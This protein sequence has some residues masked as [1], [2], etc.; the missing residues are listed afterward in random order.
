MTSLSRILSIVRLLPLFFSSLALAQTATANTSQQLVFAG[1]R[2]V[3]ALGQVNA[4]AT[5]AAGD[6][7]LAFDQKDGVRV[8]KVANDGDALL[9]QVRLGAK[10]DSGVAM[11]LDPAGNVYI[12]GTSTSGALVATSGAAMGSATAG[13]T[14]SFVAKFDANLNE[15]FLTF[16]GGTRIAASAVAASGDAVFVTGITYGADLPV[17]VNGIEQGPAYGSVQNGFVEEFS[18]DGTTLVYATYITGALGDTTPTGIAVDAGDDAWLVGSTTATGFATVAAIIPDLLSTPSGFLMR[19]TP[20]GD[21]IVFA[22]FV[23][24][25][26]L[27][28]VALDSTGV[29]LLVSG[30]VALG[31]FPVDTVTSVLVPTTYQVLLRMPLDGSSVESGTVI[32]PGLQSTVTAVSGGAVWVGG[33]FAAGTA[34]LLPQAALATI[35]TG[36]AVRVTPLVGIDETVRLGGL[37]NQQQ[38][39]A[40]IPVLV[41]GLAVDALGELIAGGAAQPTAS[42]NLLGTETYD[43]PLRG[44]PTAALPSAVTD[45]ELTTATCN[46]SLCAGSAGYLAKVDPTTAMAALTFSMDDLPFVTL[47]NLGSA[48]ANGLQLTATAGSLTSNCGAALAPGAECDALLSGGAAGTLTASASNA[49]S[50]SAAYGSYSATAPTNT[51]VFFPKELDFGVQTSASAAGVRTITVS[52]LGTSSATFTSGIPTTPESTTPFKEAASDCTL[53]GSAT[54]KVLAAGASCHISVGFSASSLA[55]NDGFVNGEWTIGIRQVLLT[56]YG[57]AAT[58]SVSA[59]EVDFGTEF[60]G[61]TVLPRYLYL[62]NSSD[63]VVPHTAVSL[64]PGSPFTVTD[65]CPANLGAGSVCRIRLDYL[66]ATVPSTDSVTLALDQGLTVLLT[67]VTMPQPTAGGASVNPSLTVSPGS[68]T[69][70][71]AVVVTGVSNVTQTIGVTNSGA[72]DFSLSLGLTG[73]FTD[74]T[75]CSS[76]LAAGATCAVAIEF[77]PSQPGARQGLLTVT[78][79]AGT[80]PVNVALSGTGTAILAN[81]NG[82]LDFGGVPV[83]QPLEQFYKVTQPFDSLTVAVTGPYRVTLIEDT[84][85][86][87]GEPPSSAFVTSGTGTCHNCWVGLRFQPVSAGAQTGTLTFSSNP[88][89]LPYVLQLTGSGLAA[90]GLIMTPSVEDFGAVP[91]NSASG[92][93]LFTLTNLTTAGAA[94]TVTAP[95]VTDDFSLSGTPTGGAA[96]SGSL[97]YGA[98]CL[99]EVIFAPTATGA[100]SGTLTLTTSAGNAMAPLVGTGTVDPGIGISPLALTFANV[101]GNAATTQNV[102]V[103]NTGAATVQIGTPSTGTASFTASASCGSLGA[104]ASCTVQVSFTPGSAPVTDTLSIPVTSADSGGVPQTNTYMIGLAGTYTTASAGLEIV[105]GSANYGPAATVTEGLVRQFTI[106]NQTA[107]T[108]TLTMSLPRDYGLAGAPCATL[109]PNSSCNFEVEFVPLTNGDLPGTIS[110]QA[111][112]SDG[113]ATLNSL[114]YAEGF[115]VGMG[116]LTISGGLIV[117]GVYNFGQVAAGQSLAQTFT[118]ANEGVAGSPPIT[119]RRV[120]SAPPFLSTTTCGTALALGQNCTVTVTFAPG[121][122]AASGSGSGADAGSL[123]IESDAQSSPDVINL[124]GQAGTTTGTPVTAALATFTLT[125]SSLSFQMT[126]VGDASTAQTVTLTNTGTTAI[127]VAS[128]TATPDF[129][130]RNGCTTVT[131]GATCSISVMS[132]P[133]TAGM[134]LAALEIASDATTS[135]EFVSLIGVGGASPLSFSPDALAFGAVQIGSK[136]VLPVQ[137]AN[138]GTTSVSFTSVNA[139]GDYAAGGNCPAAGGTLAPQAS[140]TVQV[141]FAPTATGVRTGAL[142][143]TSSASTTPLQ[144]ALSGTG[145][146][147]LLSAT[148]SSLAFGSIALGASANLSLT[149][150][151]KGSAALTGLTL[152]AAGDYA[153][154][155]PCP[156]TTL[157]VGASCTV[158]VTFTPTALGPRNGTLTIASSDPTSPLTV[159]L[160]GTGISNG[161]FTLT[162]NGG[163]SASLTLTSGEF[164]TYALL[165]T[166][167]GS[168]SG[169]V[170]LT[171]TPVQTVQYAS[172]SLLPSMVNLDSGAA[173]AAATVNTIDIGSGVMGL[174]RPALGHPDRIFLALLLPGLLLLFRRGKSVRRWLGQGLAL[175]A[176]LC[177]LFVSGCGGGGPA[178]LHYTPAGTYQFLVTASSTSGTQITQ[179][180]TLNLVVTPR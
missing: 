100:H 47:R 43:L 28:S 128:A 172:C 82:T 127:H 95:T 130:V 42:A 55:V 60:Q 139:T 86:G 24:G 150:A 105:P 99:V 63:G 51:L 170:A 77:A 67:G 97:A 57:Q 29:M 22:T 151:N 79:G 68:A 98:S 16:T 2:S 56:G 176:I 125:Q 114:A 44:V 4:V 53:A 69:F 96:C 84:G 113:S 134:H 75:S 1:L 103:T 85:Y 133:Q 102:T 154:T 155:I 27:S 19:L 32:A 161:T 61:G 169:N 10:G 62:S 121:S 129:T 110:V 111:V 137:V 39:Y 21:G 17:T 48:V 119:V 15:L 152:S 115:G 131:A 74:V 80:A 163:P 168:F 88:Q 156:Q 180:V 126:T 59:G 117:N 107:K 70:G 46:G 135:L 164:A 148:P 25:P 175:V 109:Q 104:G 143:F 36:Y 76:V 49:A 136:A 157:A 7:Y 144:V 83:G 140:C 93:V 11:A 40:S 166:P 72:S 92:A 3:G 101:G 167:V 5:D 147:S 20:A 26:G 6:I 65:G 118:L 106:N 81:N 132:T 142:M 178:N 153:V 54:M 34:P 174:T 87:H 122:Q 58:L 146:A 23:P 35:G 90:T 158:Q 173:S 112:P 162:V 78:A 45:A 18:A 116:A 171:C 177:A 149:L 30:A 31:Q 165:V 66:S 145:T 41:N 38:T 91:V 160:T 89:G 159:P 52:N 94:V 120:T 71:D 138:T 179:T 124:A 123:T 14:N 33:D 50:E 13:T 12:A 8:L 108:L 73:D 141:T 37:A 64:P 9:A